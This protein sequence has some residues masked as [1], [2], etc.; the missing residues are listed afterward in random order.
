MKTVPEVIEELKRKSQGATSAG[1]VVLFGEEGAAVMDRDR[2]DAALELHRLMKR[3]GQPFAV[4]CFVWD[5]QPQS[6][7][8]SRL[9]LLDEAAAD[10][11]SPD[12]LRR[13]LEAYKEGIRDAFGVQ[14]LET[15]H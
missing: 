7:I 6:K 4:L 8:T 12:R 1:L 3:G 14:E 11:A 9:E 5:G 10:P 2:P 15:T 13:F